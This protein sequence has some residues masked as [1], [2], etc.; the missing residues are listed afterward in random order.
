[1]ADRGKAKWSGVRAA[2]ITLRYGLAFVS[3]AAAFGLA[4]IF[5]YF[6]LPQPFTAFALCAIAL[7]FWYGGNKPGI[8]AALLS[9][10]VRGYF[11]DPETNIVSR[12]LYD[13]YL[14]IIVLLSLQGRFLSSAVVS[15]IAVGCSGWQPDEGAWLP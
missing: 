14:I 12:V 3:V 11:F 5:L 7:A 1:M 6:D 15:F 10:V 2:F 4:H 8:L 13:L 9:M